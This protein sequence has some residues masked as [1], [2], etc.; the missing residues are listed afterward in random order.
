MYPC[1]HTG[2][3]HPTQT[4]RIVDLRIVVEVEVAVVV[5]TAGRRTGR[6][7]LWVR[8]VELP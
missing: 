1:A 8:Q 4:R 2:H 3:L 6:R 5:G 7:G